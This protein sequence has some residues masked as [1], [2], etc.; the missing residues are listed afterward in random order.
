MLWTVLRAMWLMVFKQVLANEPMKTITAI[1][2]PAF[3]AV[4]TVE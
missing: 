1:E 3:V 2:H 4:L